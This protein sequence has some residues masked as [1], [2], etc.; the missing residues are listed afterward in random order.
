M[1]TL[2]LP[3]EGG[4]RESA[5]GWGSAA[6]PHPSPQLP[7]RQ[8]RGALTL[9]VPAPTPAA[10]TASLILTRGGAARS[11]L[12]L[13]SCHELPTPA[14]Q[15][16]PAGPPGDPH[17]PGL[18]PSVSKSLSIP[19]C[20]ISP[21]CVFVTVYPGHLHSRARVAGRMAWDRGPEDGVWVS[22]RSGVSFYDCQ[23]A[24]LGDVL[25]AVSP[26]VAAWKLWVPR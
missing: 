3:E 24:C 26:Y 9:L 16:A 23:C 13:W 20:P 11:P 1:P 12:H 21:L 2:R 22:P 19:I 8:G 17:P 25:Q 5:W 4:L 10:G 7:A 18:S 14:P 15:E 6:A